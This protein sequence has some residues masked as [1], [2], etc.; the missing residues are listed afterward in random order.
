MLGSADGWH[1]KRD[2][3]DLLLDRNFMQ[4]AKTPV[5]NIH[6]L[7]AYQGFLYINDGQL[8][9]IYDFATRFPGIIVLDKASF[10]FWIDKYLMTQLFAQ[11][12]VLAGIKPKWG[13]YKKEYTPDLA[14]KILTDLACDMF[15]IKPRGEF[16]GNGVIITPKEKL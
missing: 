12:P 13:N 7:A 3:I 5:S 11:D 10:P 6:D 9:A 16:L 2:I 14:A 1:I 4:C 15:V 8:C